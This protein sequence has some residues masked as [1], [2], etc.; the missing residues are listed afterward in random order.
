[1]CAG[2]GEGGEGNDTVEYFECQKDGWNESHRNECG[3]NIKD[4]E[5][6]GGTNDDDDYVIDDEQKVLG[7]NSI[8]V[9]VVY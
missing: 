3:K 1:M 7:E 4:E 8:Q 6:R 9:V 2:E 5:V